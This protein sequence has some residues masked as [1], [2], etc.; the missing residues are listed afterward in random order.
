MSSNREFPFFSIIMPTYNRANL[1]LASIQTAI[2]QE[3]P[4][5]EIIVVDDGSTDNTEE[6][7]RS[8]NHPKVIYHKKKNEERAAARNTGTQLAQGD[9]VTFFDSDDYLYPYH[10]TEAIKLIEKHHRPE[11][12]YLAYN[13]MDTDKKVIKEQKISPGTDFNKKLIG[14]NYLSC[15]GVF[16]RRDVALQ[17]P[18]NTNRTLSASEDYDLWL[19]LAARYKIYYSD[20]ITSSIL[21][22]DA[23]SV[24]VVKEKPLTDRIL[25]LIETCTNDP[26]IRKFYKGKLDVFVSKCYLYLALHLAMS[27]HK[28]SA[29]SYFIKGIKQHPL[30]IFDIRVYGIIKCLII[31]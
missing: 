13:V 10:L 1:I 30:S 27:K 21:N 28:K 9:Y 25:L 14:G 31:Y 7:I 2:A 4:H 26:L 15:N 18:F 8:L 20:V 6:V 19:R 22:H 3:Y 16:L 17:H 5:F 11:M 24:F 23:R 29:I 12:I